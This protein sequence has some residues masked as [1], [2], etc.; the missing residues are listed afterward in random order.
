MTNVLTILVLGCLCGVAWALQAPLSSLISRQTG[1]IESAFI[2]H[3]G[4][5][6][7]A[8][9]LLPALGAASF[10][11]WRGIP[12]YAYG[13]GVLGVVAIAALVTMV[14][15]VGAATTITVIIA[16]Q[17]LAA[18]VL[19]HF[20]VLGLTQRSL[21]PGRAAGFALMLLGVWQTLRSGA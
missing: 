10:A 19:D 9:A 14:P 6:V 7:A 5:A 18:A 15:R 13:A 3:L 4:G 12:W 1:P 20:G 8:L 21:D 16:A 2:V 11:A 17:L